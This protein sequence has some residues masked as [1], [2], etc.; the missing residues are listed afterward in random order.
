MILDV[1]IKI[2]EELDST[3][4]FR[5]SCREGI[6]GSCSMSINDK[7]TLACLCPIDQS[8]DEECI[9]PLP[10]SFIIKDLVIDMTHFYSQY[11]TIKP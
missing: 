1:L 8:L 7:N 9:Q 10:K 6:C 4:S 11:R 2:K 3:L 5:R